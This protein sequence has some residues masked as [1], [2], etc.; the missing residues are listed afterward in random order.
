[1]KRVVGKFLIFNAL[2]SFFSAA[3]NPATEWNMKS[4]LQ[5]VINL[6]YSLNDF[7]GSG[8]YEKYIAN[9]YFEDRTLRAMS[10]AGYIGEKLLEKFLK[11]IVF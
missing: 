8:L 10:D 2:N 3:R 1:M 6:G 11:E 4:D 9:K 5:H 7:D